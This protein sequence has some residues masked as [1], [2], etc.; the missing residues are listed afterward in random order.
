M[1]DIADYYRELAMQED[2]EYEY[3]SSIANQL[4]ENYKA[5]IAEWKSL[6]GPILVI[7]MDDNHIVNALKMLLRKDNKNPVNE[8]FIDIFEAEIKKRKIQIQ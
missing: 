5:G 2:A 1:G 8:M 7:H 3:L 6:K 4:W